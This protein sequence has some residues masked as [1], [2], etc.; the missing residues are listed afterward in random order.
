MTVMADVLRDKA[1][2]I[3]RE[4]E[5]CK[6]EIVGARLVMSLRN[7]VQSW[8]VFDVQ[9]AVAAAG[10]SDERILSD[11][12]IEFPD[13][14]DRV[15]DVT[16]LAEGAKDPYTDEDILAAVEIVPTQ[17][18]ANDTR[19]KVRQYARHG[20]PACLII[21]PFRGECTLLTRPA[22]NDY[23]ARESFTYGETVTLRL[24][25]GAAVPIPTHRFKRRED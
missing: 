16:I 19:I 25:G 4:H 7:S 6:V 13:G 12:L 8:T 20:V 15:P 17:D 14:P 10:I 9:N 18:D 5:G 24:A 1:D 2:R 21:D 11:V 23:A 22:G 3:A